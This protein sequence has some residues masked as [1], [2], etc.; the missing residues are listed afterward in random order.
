MV[1]AGR[2]WFQF[3]REMMSSGNDSFVWTPSPLSP[4]AVAGE[5]KALRIRPP[6]TIPLFFCMSSIHLTCQLGTNVI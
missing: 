5:G 6:A 4:D 1:L 3:L 2:F